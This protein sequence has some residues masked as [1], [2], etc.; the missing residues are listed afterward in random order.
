MSVFQRAYDY[1]GNQL[2]LSS[3]S[4]TKA[5]YTATE[6]AC[7]G[8]GPYLRSPDYLGRSS[9]VKEV[10]PFKQDN[11]S[12]EDVTVGMNNDHYYYMYVDNSN[13]K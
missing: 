1:E 11:R 10:K 9:E 12:D 4:Y 8:Q 13:W 5:G 6:V 2:A 3:F 7:G